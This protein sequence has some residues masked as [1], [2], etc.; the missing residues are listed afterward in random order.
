MAQIAVKG[1]KYAWNSLGGGSA[2]SLECVRPQKSVQAHGMSIVSLIFSLPTNNV[3][4]A[5]FVA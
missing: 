5:D 2:S 1:L 4:F 3:S